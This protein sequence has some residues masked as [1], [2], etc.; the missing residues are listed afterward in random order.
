VQS[1]LKRIYQALGIHAAPGKVKK[2][3]V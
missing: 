3:V 1:A 2:L